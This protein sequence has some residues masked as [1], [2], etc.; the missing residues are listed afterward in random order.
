MIEALPETL[1]MAVGCV[2]CLALPFILA[3]MIGELVQSG[4]GVA[5]SLAGGPRSAC[6]A[7]GLKVTKIGPLSGTAEG[8]YRGCHVEVA[9]EVGPQ[10]GFD[11]AHQKTWVRARA[12]DPAVRAAVSEA[13]EEASDDGTVSIELSGVESDRAKL[14]AALGRVTALAQGLPPS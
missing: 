1:K 4:R 12:E 13:T 14:E 11:A 10:S 7:L 5:K 9:W 8:S 6:E 3:W 2:G